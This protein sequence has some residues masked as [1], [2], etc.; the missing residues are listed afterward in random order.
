MNIEDLTKTQLL[1]LTILVNFV[2]SIATG[3][4]TVSLLDQA[5][6]TVIQT[7]N[8]IVDHTIETVTTEVPVVRNVPVSGPSSEDLLTSAITEDRGRSVRLY[9]AGAQTFSGTGLY[10]PSK[11]AVFSTTPGLPG[12]IT[13]EFSDGTRVEGRSV[14]HEGTAERYEFAPESVLPGASEPAFKSPA[15][16]KEGQTVIARTATGTVTT[17]IITQLSTNTVVTDLPPVPAG[18]A[19]VN[20]SGDVVGMS[21]PDGS[22]LVAHSI[23]GSVTP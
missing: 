11:R 4:L 3:V 16:L 15:D 20:L 17:G 19:V 10:V 21:M 23:M 7:V 22:L 14:T 12:T 5:P 18:T 9:R 1:L 8:R 6:P 13:V 2:T